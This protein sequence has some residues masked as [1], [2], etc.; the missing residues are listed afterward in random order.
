MTFHFV[1]VTSF[2]L[3]CI[4]IQGCKVE[5]QAINY[6]EDQC[7]SCKM[8]ISDSRFGSE[9]VTKK[10]KIYKYD[11]IE[12]MVREV[13]EQGEDKYAHIIVTDYLKPG[14]FLDARNATFLIHKE[15]PSPMGAN[16]SAYE[17]T[18]LL[19]ANFKNEDQEALRWKA[20][21]KHFEKK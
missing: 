3:V 11:A 20:L 5:P 18:K 15:R 2:I 7:Q 16:L 12:C 21:K 10:G 4:F 9:L 1:K 14:A 17:S 6:N 8:M 19:S 13:I